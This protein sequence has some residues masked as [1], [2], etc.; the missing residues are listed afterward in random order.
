MAPPP[1]VVEISSEEDVHYPEEDEDLHGDIQEALREGRTIVPATG[2]PHV[3]P[4]LDVSSG[5]SDPGQPADESLPEI[6]HFEKKFELHIEED[7]ESVTCLPEGRWAHD[8]TTREHW[9]GVP[10]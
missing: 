8:H 6:D 2:A 1:A 5:D 7:E 10:E 9:G 4:P 3:P